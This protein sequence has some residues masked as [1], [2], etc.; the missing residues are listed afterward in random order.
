MES[1]C[2]RHACG[3]QASCASQACIRGLQLRTMDGSLTSAVSGWASTR[4]CLLPGL[5][6]FLLAV[7]IRNVEL[8][9][10]GQPSVSLSLLLGLFVSLEDL[11]P[12]HRLCRQEF[13]GA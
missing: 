2:A 13:G 11:Q 9:V 1:P 7:P 6:P 12:C 3:A 10:G 5:E 8:E 4:T